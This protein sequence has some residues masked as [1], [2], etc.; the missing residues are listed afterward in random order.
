MFIMRSSGNTRTGQMYHIC[1]EHLLGIKTLAEKC[2]GLTGALTS[3]G[4]EDGRL[5][6]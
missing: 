3:M 6:R 4:S 2:I 5:N 1:P